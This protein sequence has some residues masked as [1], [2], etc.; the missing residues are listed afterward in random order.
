[1]IGDPLSEAPITWSIRV[2]NGAYGAS[3]HVPAV[4]DDPRFENPYKIPKNFPENS[5][6]KKIRVRICWGRF[7]E[8]LGSPFITTIYISEIPVHPKI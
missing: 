2:S 3:G 4:D 8:S 6:R 1:M 7:R 5:E